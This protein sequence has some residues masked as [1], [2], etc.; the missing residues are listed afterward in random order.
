[1]LD[2]QGL[3]AAIHQSGAKSLG[4]RLASVRSSGAFA[5][6]DAAGRMQEVGWEKYSTLEMLSWAAE[7][8]DYKAELAANLSKPAFVVPVFDR[9]FAGATATVQMPPAALL[10]SFSTLEVDMR[11]SCAG[12][13]DETCPVWDHT[14]AL[15]VV[16]AATADEAAAIAAAS[17]ERRA[18]GGGVP[19]AGAAGAPSFGEP[20]GFEGELARWVTPF[21]RRVGH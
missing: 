21:R 5:S 20:G 18:V 11:L 16:C 13:M 12:N 8:L 7:Y 9:K 15:G 6:I 1:M 14:V 17:S 19:A 4:A 3:L 10:D 2:G